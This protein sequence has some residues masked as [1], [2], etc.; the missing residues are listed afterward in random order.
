MDNPRPRVQVIQS[1]EGAV[2]DDATLPGLPRQTV[3]ITLMK[4]GT[5]LDNVIK[6]LSRMKLAGDRGLI[7]DDEADQASSNKSETVGNES[8]TSRGIVEWRSKLLNHTSRENT[9]PPRDM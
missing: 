1:I 4:N 2:R 8:A 9:R 7:V 5:H 6:I 3:L